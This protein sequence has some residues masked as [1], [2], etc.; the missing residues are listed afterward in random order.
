MSL[1]V[2]FGNLHESHLHVKVC[3]TDKSTALQIFQ[4]LSKMSQKL[5]LQLKK[6]KRKKKQR[7]GREDE[8][9][10]KRQFTDITDLVLYII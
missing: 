1:S 5:N 8:E 2:I 3:S 9:G 10:E 6:K 4:I 7:G